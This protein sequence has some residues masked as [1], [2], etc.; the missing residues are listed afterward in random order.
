MQALR[1]VTYVLT[2]LASITFLIITLWTA[3]KINQIQRAIDESPLGQ[4]SSLTSSPPGGPSEL[5]QFCSTY[6]TAT[7]C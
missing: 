1:A 5:Q 3:V 7:G 2:S 4:F 6:P